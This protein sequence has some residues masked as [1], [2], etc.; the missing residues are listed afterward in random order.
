[1][2]GT[3]KNTKNPAPGIMYL[4]ASIGASDFSNPPNT[5]AINNTG[6]LKNSHILKS[7]MRDSFSITR[8]NIGHYSLFDWLTIQYVASIGR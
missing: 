6:I 2:K 7:V 5:V 3:T 1:M 8:I 4:R